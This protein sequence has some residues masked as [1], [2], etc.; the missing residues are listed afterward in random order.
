MV[1]DGINDSPALAEAD[2]SVAMKDAS[3]IAKEVADVTLLQSDLHKLVTL[4]RVSA[5]LM[6][7]IRGNYRAIV[8]FNSGL[9][10]LG[11]AGLVQPGASALMHNAAT[12][13]V[14]ARSTKS[15]I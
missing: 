8:A 11:L 7:R 14:S 2:V 13:L 3:D 6:K 9:L 4:R 12:V 15:L 10:L 1:G 5:G